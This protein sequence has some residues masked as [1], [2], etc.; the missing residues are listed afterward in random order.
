MKSTYGNR[1]FGLVLFL[2][3]SASLSYSVQKDQ[4][5]TLLSRR[6]SGQELTQQEYQTLTDEVGNFT[7]SQLVRVLRTGKADAL[8]EYCRAE[9]AA[10]METP[11]NWTTTTI[12]LVGVFLSSL[13]LLVQYRNQVERRHGEIV[14]LKAQLLTTA[15]GIRQ[16]M[17]ALAIQNETI[18]LELRRLPDSEDKFRSIEKLP[19]VIQGTNQIIEEV[20]KFISRVQKIDPEKMNKTSTL[21]LF[22]RAAPEIESVDVLA[23]K[24]EDNFASLLRDIRRQIEASDAKS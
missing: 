7:H 3:L 5:D 11:T 4:I 12:A 23:R 16:R 9:L 6:A 8:R 22:Q 13:V 2:L 1:F 10:R 20:D 14:Q 24:A 18:R 21:L 15:S 17:A 19:T